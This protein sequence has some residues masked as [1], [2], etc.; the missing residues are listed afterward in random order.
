MSSFFINCVRR[1]TVFLAAVSISACGTESKDKEPT[2]QLSLRQYYDFQYNL[3]PLMIGIRLFHPDYGFP[4]SIDVYEG[5][6]LCDSKRLSTQ[7]G[8]LTLNNKS[9]CRDFTINLQYVSAANVCQPGGLYLM[10]ATVTNPDDGQANSYQNMTL[11]AWDQHYNKVV[12]WITPFDTPILVSQASK[13]DFVQGNLNT[14]GQWTYQVDYASSVTPPGGCSLQTNLDLKLTPADAALGSRLLN[15]TLSETNIGGHITASVTTGS[16]GAPAASVELDGAS[17]HLSFASLDVL[18]EASAQTSLIF[19]QPTQTAPASFT[20]I[21]PFVEIGSDL[22]LDNSGSLASHFARVFSTI[23]APIMGFYG[24]LSLE[25]HLIMKVAVSLA[26]PLS[27]QN[28]PFYTVMPITLVSD[29][30]FRPGFDD[31]TD[32]TILSDPGLSC[33]LDSAIAEY[34]A[35]HGAP[36]VTA[37]Y[38]LDITIY[39]LIEG[40]ESAVINLQK[41]VIPVSQIN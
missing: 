36:A 18:R 15:Y 27:P 20:P 7:T 19:R 26:I 41:I 8:M 40:K 16:T 31:R 5:P 10:S 39:R 11:A 28:P 6:T 2:S 34:T 23:T 24:P 1:T 17:R 29:Y 32:C 33:K 14:V 25:P 38:T 4:S 9:S 12:P 37:F 21:Q 13:S 35:T 22:W 3:A 30:T